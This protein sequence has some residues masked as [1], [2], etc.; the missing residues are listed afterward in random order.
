M[1]AYIAGTIGV[2]VLITTWATG[3]TPVVGGLM[4][5]GIFAVGVLAQ[6]LTRP[7]P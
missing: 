1:L 2:C 3:L 7:A 6:M 4:A 5:L